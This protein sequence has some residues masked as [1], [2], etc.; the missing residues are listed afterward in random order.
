[1]L[2]A[3]FVMFTR[4]DGLSLTPVFGSHIRTP[5]YQLSRLPLP[6]GSQMLCSFLHT[7]CASSATHTH[8]HTANQLVLSLTALFEQKVGFLSEDLMP[9]Q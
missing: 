4:P 2:S 6:V 5:V 7:F 8:Q 3:Y 1:M 9:L